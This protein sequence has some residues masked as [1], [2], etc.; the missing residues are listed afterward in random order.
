MKSRPADRLVRRRSTVLPGTKGGV[1]NSI[2]GPTQARRGTGIDVG[3]PNPVP[4][5]TGAIAEVVKVG[6]T[7]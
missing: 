3:V 4:R 7:N 1:A 2:C 5:R 6:V